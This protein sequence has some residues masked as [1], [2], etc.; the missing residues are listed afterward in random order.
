MEIGKRY[1]VVFTTGHYEIEYENG[2]KCIK[3]T[4]K[5][6]RVERVDGTT[7][8]IGQDSIMELK[9][10]VGHTIPKGLYAAKKAG[11][12][13]PIPKPKAKKG[14]KWIE[15]E[16]KDSSLSPLKGF[17]NGITKVAF[18]CPQGHVFKISGY[19]LVKFP[20]CPVC[21]PERFD[22]YT[23]RRVEVCE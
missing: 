23:L 17:G 3:K 21:E 5:S 10:V 19:S 16:L 1:D 12:R 2:V 18:K 14:A 8:L 4:P 22:A 11:I 6:Y 20:F 13:P 15:A 7:R 9:E